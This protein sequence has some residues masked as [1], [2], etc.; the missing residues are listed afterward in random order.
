MSWNMSEILQ[1]WPTSQKSVVGWGWVSADPVTQGKLMLP[2][3]SFSLSLIYPVW[4]LWAFDSLTSPQERAL[5]LA[6]IHVDSLEPHCYPPPEFECYLQHAN[7]LLLYPKGTGTT[8]INYDLKYAG[9]TAPAKLPDTFRIVHGVCHP[10]HR[11]SWTLCL[12]L[13][14][15]YV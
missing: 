9:F 2:I 15:L 7:C 5:P 13:T 6:S 12:S 8:L 14:T 10:G 11:L 3:T 1:S 4:P